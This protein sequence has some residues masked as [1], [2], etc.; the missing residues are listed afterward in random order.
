MDDR[1]ERIPIY[2][3]PSQYQRAFTLI[4]LVLTIVGIGV[5]V[6]IEVQWADTDSARE[7]IDAIIVGIPIVW[8]IGVVTAIL[9]VEVYGM[10]KDYLNLR[11]VRAE[12]ET[13]GAERDIA[14]RR[15]EAAEAKIETT[16]AE[17]DTAVAE[18]DDAV[19]RAEK[20]EAEL[21]RR[22]RQAKP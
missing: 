20:A 4:S 13:T 1:E 16:G 5:R 9:S 7:T 14:V 21:E 12:L 11:R 18:R 10:I 19:R 3:Y 2:S 8:L 17:R 6:W 15:A 22:S